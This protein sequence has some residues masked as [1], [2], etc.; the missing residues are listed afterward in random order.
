MK[1]LLMQA[2]TFTPSL[3]YILPVTSAG[4]VNNK[5]KPKTKKSKANGSLPARKGRVD[6]HALVLSRVRKM[7]PEQGFRSLIASGIYTSDGKLAKEY[8]D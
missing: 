4:E 7:T 2:L 8:A 5:M 3:A 1:F 6:L